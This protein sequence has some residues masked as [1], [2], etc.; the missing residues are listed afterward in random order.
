MAL[1][2]LMCAV[3]VGSDVWLNER[4][5]ANATGVNLQDG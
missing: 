5:S 2:A 3:Q 1:L 4:E